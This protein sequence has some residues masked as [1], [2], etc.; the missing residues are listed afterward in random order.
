MPISQDDFTSY[1]T[2]LRGAQKRV[3]VAVGG[4]AHG[5]GLSRY[6]RE[7]KVKVV[8]IAPPDRKTRL[9]QGRSD[10]VDAEAAAGAALA[11]PAP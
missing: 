3:R 8:E 7:H 2:D 5:A 11:E 10:P 6:L 9:W 1:I 4:M